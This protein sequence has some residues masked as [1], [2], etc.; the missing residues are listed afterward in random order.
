[1]YSVLSHKVSDLSSYKDL[2]KEVVLN[3]IKESKL[4]GRGG[5]AFP[6]YKK[7]ELFINTPANF[8]YILVNAHEGELGCLKDAYLIEN[9]VNAVLDGA[10]ITKHITSANKIII[11]CKRSD[12]KII[13]IINAAKTSEIDLHISCDKYVAGEE[14]ALI[15]EIEHGFAY[16]RPKPPY[17]TVSGLFNAPTLIH[18]AETM[19][20]IS[21]ISRYGLENFI[22]TGTEYSRGT[23][24]FSISGDVNSPGIYEIEFGVS[25]RKSI[26]EY[27]GGIKNN[28][29]AILPGFS[30][31]IKNCNSISL[32]YES[33]AAVGSNLGTG[34]FRVFSSPESLA[35]YIEN[36]IRFIANESCGQCST[37][38]NLCKVAQISVSQSYDETELMYYMNGVV[39]L[40]RCALMSSMIDMLRNYIEVHQ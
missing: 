31:I 37:C 36:V 12:Q 38:R 6:V 27:A 33:F 1:M 35:S 28:L 17:P 14:T 7:W 15:E 30:R 29:Y 11:C 25:L 39:G 34:N 18:N 32:D 22:N 5:A 8:K 23:K 21:Y 26:D 40:S 3:Y 20:H 2:N 10:L 16:P 24:L 9:N 19:A 4:I 13:N